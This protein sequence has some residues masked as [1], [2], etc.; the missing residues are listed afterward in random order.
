MAAKPNTTESNMMDWIRPSEADGPL[1]GAVFSTYGLSL[2]QP[3]FFGQDFL[4]N[5][6]GLG[7]VRDRGYASPVRLDCVLSTADVTLI[8]DAHALAAGVRP[9]LQVDVLPIGHRVHH[10]KV[11]LIHRRDRIRLIVASANLTHEGFRRQREAAV[12]MDF[13]EDGRLPPTVLTQALSR[14][15]EALGDTADAQVRRLFEGA[16]SRAREWPG[17]SRRQEDLDLQVVFGG[18]ANPVWRQ[19]VNAWPEREPVLNWHICSPFWPQVEENAANNP[20]E[21]IANGLADRGSF[22][23]D[24]DLEIITRADAPGPNAVPRFPFSLVSQLRAHGFPVEHGRILPARLGAAEEEVPEGMAVES[25]DLHAKWIVLAGP[26][27]VVAYVG[28]ANFTR[29]GLGVLRNPL[30]ANIEA[31]VLMRWMRGKWHPKDWRPPIEGQIVDWASCGPRD[32]RDPSTEEEKAPDWADFIYRVE[33]AVPWQPLTEPD[34]ELLVHLRRG[35]APAFRVG[36]PS[37]A[38]ANLSQTVVSPGAASPFCMAVSPEQ[39]RSMLSR[40][41]VEILWGEKGERCLF[42]VNI[43]HDSKARILGAKPSEEELLAYFHDRISEEDLLARLEQHARAEAGR[44]GSADPTDIDR[45]RRLQ[46]YIVREFVESLYGLARTIQDAA[47]YSPRAAEQAL[48]GDLSPVCLAEQVVQAF[49]AGKRSPTAAAFQLAELIRV[50]R[51]IRWPAGASSDC[52]RAFEE[53]GRRALDRLYA[54]VQQAALK[55]QFA[56]VM[57]DREFS[58]FVGAM[59]P[60]DLARRWAALTPEAIQKVAPEQEEAVA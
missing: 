25:R 11:I 42:P 28:S 43:L 53:V 59:L 30:T 13:H 12:V 32:V 50:V 44:G 10:A 37:L 47:S 54:L 16:A 9:T 31:G 24:C 27:T 26:K 41:V 2:D 4:P 8:C 46:S 38:G 22:L 29:Q 51:E 19:L 21:A 15:E 55:T 14:W 3:D 7:G 49:L 45:V 48:L 36:F 17:M 6:L 57:Q 20:F 18:G 23:G 52:R 39:V 60:N 5:L 1:I 33:L 58:E 34:G 56:V 35:D 40:R